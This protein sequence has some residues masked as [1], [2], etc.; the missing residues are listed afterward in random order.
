MC[1]ISIGSSPC[2]TTATWSPFPAR[3]WQ[4][5][6]LSL[7]FSL[8]HKI[9]LKIKAYLRY[10]VTWS[11][12]TAFFGE[13]QL[14]QSKDTPTI[15]LKILGFE[16]WFCFFCDQLWMIIGKPKTIATINI[17]SD[18]RN[19]GLEN[20]PSIYSSEPFLIQSFAFETR[21]K[22]KIV[23]WCWCL[24]FPRLIVETDLTKLSDC[25][26][27]AA[28]VQMIALFWW[29]EIPVAMNI[30]RGQLSA[31]PDLLKARY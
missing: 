25:F 1:V 19:S 26:S 23:R 3:T 30:H 24:D 4:S 7:T 16:Q 10:P 13:V 12:F 21:Y 17:K 9:F 22:I 29:F 20:Y 2:Q 18:N 11:K 27:G 14:K 28:K 15:S 31:P 8:S 6:T 5:I